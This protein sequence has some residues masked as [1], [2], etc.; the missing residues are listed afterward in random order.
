[1]VHRIDL[2]LDCLNPT[3]LAEFYKF[4]LGYEDEPPPPPFKTREEWLATFDLSDDDQD[5]GAWIH[6]PT[7]AR[8]RIFL[9][10]TRQPRTMKNRWHLDLRV[11]NKDDPRERR[12][13]QISETVERLKTAGALIVQEDPP[14][15]VWM[16]DPEG[17]DFCVA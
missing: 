17:N 11:S 1:M 2:T 12:W 13:E 8:P 7:G 6:D 3:K 5:D 4:A 9:Q 16:A 15:S 10:H 14:R